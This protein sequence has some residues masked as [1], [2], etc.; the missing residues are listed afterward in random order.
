[1]DG[2]PVALAQPLWLLGL[3]ALPLLPRGRGRPWRAAALAALLLAL[4]DPVA[5]RP[6]ARTA[7]VVDVSDS[8]R[9]ASL[10]AARAT[11]AA[12][13]P[14]DAELWLAAGEPAEVA[15]L[16]SDVDP[17]LRPGR[18][19]LARALS[20]VAARG[21]GR[22]LLISDGRDTRGALDAARPPVPVDVL[23][24]A[25][26]DNARVA[27]LDLPVDAAPG[28]TVRVEAR[29]ASDRTGPARV[30]LRV[31]D[32]VVASRRVQLESGARTAAF[33]VDLPERGPVRVEASLAVGWSQPTADDALAATLELAAR[34]PVWVVGDPAAA[35][36]LR[37][38]GVDVRELAP[39]ELELP[40]T[41]GAVVLRAASNRF[42]TGQLQALADWVDDGG[43]LLMTG[44]PQSFG[45]GGW[46]RTPVEA[47]LPVDGDLRSDVRVPLVAMVM[48][49]DRS[50]SMAGGSPSK[51]GL[52]RQGAAEVVELAFERDL[53]G[54]IAFSD[55]SEWA[56]ELRPATARG[57]L[58]MLAAIRGLATGGGTLLGP[59]LEEAL[60]AL[61]DS[62]AAIKHAI[63]LSDGRLYDGSGP[64]AGP[65]VDL[66]GEAEAAREDGISISTIAVGAEADFARLRALA[67]AGG[68]RYYEA[69]DVATLPRIFAGEALT[70]TRS[71]VREDPGPPA[72]RAHP[73]L[74]GLDAPPA[75]DAYVATTLKA[76]AE[77]L[78]SYG[79]EETLLSVRRQGL[80]RTAAFTTDLSA[81]AGELGGWSP[82]PRLLAD[83]VR[84]L[85]ARPDRFAAA[86][87]DAGPAG[88]AELRV[89]AVEDGRFLDGLALSV[90]TGG[91]ELPLRSI[92]PGRYGARLPPSA[93]GEPVVVTDGREVVARARFLAQDPEFA[94][95]DGHATLRA[96]AETSGGRVLEAGAAWDPG[97]AP[98]PRSLAG[99]AAAAAAALVLGELAAR[100]LRRG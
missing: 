75:P 50:Q 99:W 97:P 28:A 46:Y 88:G 85:A 87:Q 29:L 100:R 96:L 70:A 68:G 95:A 63:V 64:F 17:L 39:E 67:E 73:L 86:L 1:V 72:A 58:E 55:E 80:G 8:A 44:G 69:L 61:R 48:V 59:A 65:P 40:I 43:G 38:Q 56:F 18:S 74:V 77:A 31:G 78:W 27:D 13:V 36:L 83:V 37:E 25:T 14:E 15:A 22:I 5:P 62:D 52:A 2:L 10:E 24:V 94:E 19:D 54:L 92:G 21:V 7:V 3:L 76:D 93:A 23:P 32:A 20:T 79:P 90:R 53:L 57:K 26:R 45:L 42:T 66:V 84:W 35:R 41:A 6:A 11:R 34:D 91:E 4:A 89:D 71:L 33:R 47:V 81:W 12:G 60:D 49:L 30:E 98:R 9:P 82:L 51:I 16:P